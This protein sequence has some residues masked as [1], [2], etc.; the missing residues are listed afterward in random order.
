M[1]VIKQTLAALRKKVPIANTIHH[2]PFIYKQ[3]K[4]LNLCRFYSDR[5]INHLMSILISIF[6]SGYSGKTTDFAKN[7][8]CHRTTIAHF[9]NRGKWDD[10]LLSDILKKSVIEIIYSEAALTGKP[11]FCIVDDT[12]ASKTKPSSQALHPIENAY[13]HQSHLKGKQDYGHQAVAIM[14]SCNGIVLNYAFVLYDKSISKIDIVQNIAKELPVPPVKS[15]F[16]CDSWYVSEKII[17]TFAV[18][19]FHTIGALKTNRMLYPSGIKKKLSEFAALL[20]VTHSD[21]D[22]VTVKNKNYYVYRYEGK[23]N[24]IENAVVLL[25]YPENAFGKPKALRAFI[26]TDVS[27][28]TNEILSYYV[29]RWSV[30]VFFRQC[31]DKLALDS[32]QIRSAQGICRYWL[33][34]SLAHYICVAGTDELCSFENG[35]HQ[36]CDIIDHEKYQYLF[37]CAKECDDFNSFMSLIA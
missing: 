32:Y 33:I 30:E 23:L 12:I 7:S 1:K 34:M 9:L 31:K 2:S 29:C 24:G 6:I 20:S 15:Y 3:F 25:S 11:V 37:R 10:S 17:N 26:S 16:L 14:L 8:T 13:F 36:I 4:V 27:L 19:G 5:I 28:S 35:Y 21:F 22:L 18:N